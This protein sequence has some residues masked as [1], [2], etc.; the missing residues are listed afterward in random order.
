MCNLMI[1]K[2]KM[3]IDIEVRGC[4]KSHYNVYN[5]KYQSTGF[6]VLL[7]CRFVA[8]STFLFCVAMFHALLRRFRLCG[9]HI[10]ENKINHL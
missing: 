6:A 9:I 8:V 2:L 3:P 1:L 5:I 7:P 10:K 4:N